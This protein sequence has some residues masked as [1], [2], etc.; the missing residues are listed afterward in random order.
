MNFYYIIAIICTGITIYI[1]I[2]QPKNKIYQW[3]AGICTVAVM[4]LSYMAA[5]IDG[6]ASETSLKEMITYQNSEVKRLSEQNIGLTQVIYNN[7]NQ[8]TGNGSYPVCYVGG[9]KENETQILMG[10]NGKY[11][12]PNL[13]TRIVSLPN[14][15]KI[16]GLDLRTV[17]LTNPT[18]P[19][20]TI[21]K[22]EMKY[23]FV[24]SKTKETAVTFFFKSDNHS[25]IQSIRIIQT[26]NGRKSFW[27]IQDEDGKVIDKYIDNDFPKTKDG[28]LVIWSNE[29]KS[30]E[31]I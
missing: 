5:K 24:E 6:E 1:Q 2:T 21:R 26:P 31:E 20:G 4:I 10:V 30:F 14:Y 23:Q 8:M 16:S 15:K 25:W 11:A 22:N 13:T 7:T 18:I 29:I 28:K 17:G 9:G 12:L 3:V 27:F 19:L